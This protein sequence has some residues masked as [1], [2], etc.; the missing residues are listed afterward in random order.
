[1]KY[2]FLFFFAAVFYSCSSK[3][4][5]EREVFN[6][7]NCSEL[8]SVY[9]K[10]QKTI[11]IAT[12]YC[13]FD[14][15]NTDSL[16]SVLNGLKLV[17]QKENKFQSLNKYWQGYCYVSI[18]ACQLNFKEETNVDSIIHEGISVLNSVDKKNSEHYALLSMLHGISIKYCNIAM[19]SITAQKSKLCAEEAIQLN[20]K[21]MRAYL[22]F[23]INDFFTPTIYSGGKLVEESLKKALQ[24]ET[25]IDPNIQCLPSWG[26]DIVYEYLIKNYIKSKKYDMADKYLKEVTKLFPYRADLQKLNNQIK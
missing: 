9:I 8:D 5:H 15:K 20:N 10:A 14:S 24:L 1:M 11:N 13:L 26:K 12:R 22:A 2:L 17:C 23:A 19:L 18:V 16:I 21:N 6:I 25:R 3:Y 7:N 4:E